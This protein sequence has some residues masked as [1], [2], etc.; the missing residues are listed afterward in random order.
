MINSGFRLQLLRLAEERG[1]LGDV[2][3]VEAAPPEDM[4]PG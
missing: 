3:A 2:A 4:A 1:L